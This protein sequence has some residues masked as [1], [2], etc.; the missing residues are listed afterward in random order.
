[1]ES[2]FDEVQIFN[3]LEENGK[4][5]FDPTHSCV[6]IFN[7]TDKTAFL[8]FCAHGVSKGARLYLL[9]DPLLPGEVERDLLPEIMKIQG[10]P[11]SDELREIA[12]EK[13]R[14][15]IEQK[16]ADGYFFDAH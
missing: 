4:A 16:R 13:I 9:H 8:F 12:E 2:L 3:I 15:I 5:D 11:F 7:L 14:Y 6:D 1:M 10:D